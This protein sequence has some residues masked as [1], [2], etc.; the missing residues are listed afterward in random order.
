MNGAIMDPILPLV[1]QIA[2]V[3]PREI[4]G[5]SSNVNALLVTFNKEV[6]NFPK[7]ENVTITL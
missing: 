5:K 7:S 4:V 3:M 6:Q 2:R 1:E